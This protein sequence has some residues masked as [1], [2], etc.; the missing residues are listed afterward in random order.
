MLKLKRIKPIGSQILISGNEYLEDD[1]N[2]AGLIEGNHKKGS[3]KTF[4]TV[5]AVG[6][7]VRF[8]KVGDVVEINFYK[9]AVF[10][11]DPNS[12]KAMADNPIVGFRLNWVSLEDGDCIIVD[13]RD[14]QY[15]IEDSEEVTYA[16]KLFNEKAGKQQLILPSNRIK[17]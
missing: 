6:D 2:E 14:V 4:Q 16:P 13:Q 7:D 5:L 17:M 3:L 11:E 15:I 1:Y 10:K 8:V 12:I 9:Y